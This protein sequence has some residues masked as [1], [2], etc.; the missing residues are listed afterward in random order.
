MKNP[1][2][3]IFN[4][5]LFLIIIFVA[6]SSQAIGRY[7]AS[8]YLVVGNYFFTMWVLLR[9]LIPVIVIMLM[10]IPVSELGLGLPVI[11]KKFL[12]NLIILAVI[13]CLAFAG[14]YFF[15]DYFQSYSG[16]FHASNY[17]KL[18]RFANFMIFTSSTLTG[19]EFLHRC[20]L[21]MGLVYVFTHRERLDWE[22]AVKISIGIVWIFEVVFHFIKPGL[23]AFGMI[24]GSPILS[25]L[26]IRTKS[27]WTP[28]LAHLL[29]E[30]LF[31][32]SLLYQY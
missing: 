14:I 28:F 8:R 19:W 6:I 24:F 3:K 15:K 20:F 4:I 1:F 5:P 30:I 32:L 31:I 22:L 7:Y 12:K 26:A 23:E 2:N 16:S 29:V 11:D 18:S 21:L 25:Y 27:I 13:L 9:I 10:R 17:S